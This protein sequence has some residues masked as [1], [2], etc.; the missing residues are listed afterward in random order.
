M[1]RSLSETRIT[2]KIVEVPA[3]VSDSL[4]RERLLDPNV[5]GIR[6]IEPD[7]VV[8]RLSVHGLGGVC[9]TLDAAY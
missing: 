2:C 6:E 3:P 4:R 9:R 1:D 5:C 8:L 7:V